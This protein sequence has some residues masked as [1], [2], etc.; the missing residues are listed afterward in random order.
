MV[1]NFEVSNVQTP[2][3]GKTARSQGLKVKLLLSYIQDPTNL[4]GAVRVI[5]DDHKDWPSRDYN[6]SLVRIRTNQNKLEWHVRVLIPAPMFFF[7]PD[8]LRQFKGPQ[9][10][11]GL[12]TIKISQKSNYPLV[13]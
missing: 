11:L 8:T 12:R 6:K 9:D 3:I 1:D 5:R 10:V 4:K 13:N 7:G 2:C